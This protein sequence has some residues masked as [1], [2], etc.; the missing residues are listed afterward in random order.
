[1]QALRRVS[2]ASAGQSR[3]TGAVREEAEVGARAE[4]WPGAGSHRTLS[5]GKD[6]GFCSE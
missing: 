5:H 4:R 1:M 3:E 2:L 6:F